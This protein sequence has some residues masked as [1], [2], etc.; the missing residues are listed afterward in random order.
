M[1]DTGSILIILASLRN[2]KEAVR[3]VIIGFYCHLPPQFPSVVHFP[4]PAGV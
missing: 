4:S 2:L 3:P 1:L